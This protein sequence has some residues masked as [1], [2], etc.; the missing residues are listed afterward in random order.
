MADIGSRVVM[1]QR[2]PPPHKHRLRWLRDRPQVAALGRRRGTLRRLALRASG[3]YDPDVP[4]RF[5][6][7][8]LAQARPFHETPCPAC[9]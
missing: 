1:P 5:D 9:P 8:P 2:P 3:A 4:L 6:L 7:R